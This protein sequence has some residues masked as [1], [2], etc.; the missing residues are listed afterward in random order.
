MWF[1]I[2][3]QN[4]ADGKKIMENKEVLESHFNSDTVKVEFVKWVNKPSIDDIDNYLR[5]LLFNYTRIND[6]EYLR[7][8]CLRYKGWIPMKIVDDNQNG[9]LDFN[10]TKR[11][12]ITSYDIFKSIKRLNGRINHLD[13]NLIN[14]RVVWKWYQ[15]NK[16]DE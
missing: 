16:A 6:D 4:G 7:N 13:S 1:H 9:L 15:N 3:L 12:R 2:I 11:N 5:N 8:L 10:W 14:S